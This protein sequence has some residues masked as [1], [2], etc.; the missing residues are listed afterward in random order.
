MNFHGKQPA[1]C[2]EHLSSGTADTQNGKNRRH[3]GLNAPAV[4][5]GILASEQLRQAKNTL[6][7]LA[8]LVSHA[9]IQGVMEA[10]EALLY[11]AARDSTIFS[12]SQICNITWSLILPTE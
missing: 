11:S 12:R 10:D 6:V 5:G 9:A 2:P 4:N 8:T 3:R 1:E 7:V